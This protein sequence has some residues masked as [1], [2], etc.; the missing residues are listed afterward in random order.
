MNK[1]LFVVLASEFVDIITFGFAAGYDIG[2]QFFINGFFPAHNKQKLMLGMPHDHVGIIGGKLDDPVVNF[3]WPD[4]LS[5]H[6]GIICSGYLI[7]FGADGMNF[8][9]VRL[10]VGGDYVII[11][12]FGIPVVFSDCFP[13][14]LVVYRGNRV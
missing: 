4:K 14:A 12:S 8:F 7:N 10:F 3:E 5:L 11:T 9:A 1:L 13:A 2:I 6:F